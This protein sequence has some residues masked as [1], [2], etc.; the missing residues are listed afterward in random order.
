MLS[1]AEDLLPAGESSVKGMNI[2]WLNERQ[3]DF[4]LYPGELL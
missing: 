2:I 3:E 1:L 4:S